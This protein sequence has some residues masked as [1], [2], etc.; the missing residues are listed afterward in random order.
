MCVYA[1]CVLYVPPVYSPCLVFACFAGWTQAINTLGMCANPSDEQLQAEV[2]TAQRPTRSIQSKFAGPKK[3]QE[4]N[5]RTLIR[6]HTHTHTRVHSLPGGQS[7]GVQGSNREGGGDKGDD[8]RFT[9][10]QHEEH[11]DQDSE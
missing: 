11:R 7:Y 5:I 10:Q 9:L 8:L 6:T 3:N 1:K 4:V 2:P